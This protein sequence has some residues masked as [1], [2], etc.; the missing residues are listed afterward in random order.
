MKMEWVQLDDTGDTF[1]KD[2]S[3][4]EEEGGDGQKGCEIA[5]QFRGDIGEAR[6]GVGKI[7]LTGE[8]RKI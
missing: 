2:I 4:D 1:V 5:E 8:R 6:G 3:E 7:S